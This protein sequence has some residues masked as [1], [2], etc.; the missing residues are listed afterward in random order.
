[1]S[2]K[3]ADRSGQFVIPGDKIGVIE[4]FVPGPG[5]YVSDGEIYSSTTGH[6]MIDASNKTVSVYPHAHLPIIP[7]EGKIVTGQVSMVQD[8]IAVVQIFNIG[9]KHPSGLFTGNIH[10]SMVSRGFVESMFNALKTGDIILAK[11]INDKN[12][13]YQLSI[14]D[15][16]LGVLY[17]FCSRCGNLL[18]L[19]DHRLQ[20]PMCKNVEE[21]KIALEYGVA[22]I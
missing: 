2:G 21:R 17:A 18:I 7:Q 4:E 8:K 1:L 13:S 12:A 3:T 6:M 14:A 22:A 15:R 9:K 5:T 20:C 11:V 19:N 10:I 16:E